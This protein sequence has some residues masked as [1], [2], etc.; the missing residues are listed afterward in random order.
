WKAP[1]A[2]ALASVGYDLAAVPVPDTTEPFRDITCRQLGAGVVE[3]AFHAYNG[4]MSTDLCE[5]LT[6]TVTACA[7]R[8]DIRLLVLRGRHGTA[9]SNGLHLGEIG[10]STEPAGAAW[11]NINAI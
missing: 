11:R 6:R 9:F 1:A 4:A 8:R 3:V 7:S 5:R 2:A 10:I